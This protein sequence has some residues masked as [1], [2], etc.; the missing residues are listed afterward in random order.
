MS[1]RCAAS[2]CSRWW[3]HLFVVAIVF[4]SPRIISAQEEP[5]EP[6]TLAYALRELPDVLKPPPFLNDDPLRAQEVLLA[7]PFEPRSARLRRVVESIDEFDKYKA[8]GFVKALVKE[9]DD[10]SGLPFLVGKDARL[11]PA[12]AR[13]FARTVAV[14]KGHLKEVDARQGEEIARIFAEQYWRNF[15]KELARLHQAG[16]GADEERA[17]TAALMQILLPDGSRHREFMAKRFAKKDGIETTRAL[18][19]LAL[20]APDDDVRAEAIKGLQGRPVGDYK[21]ILMQGFRYPL[22]AVARRAATALV[23]LECRDVL[24]NLIAVLEQPDPRAPTQQKVDGKQLTVVR[25]LVRFNHLR[26]CLL[27]HAPAA[28]RDKDGLTARMPL[29]DEPLVPGPDGYHGSASADFRVR[30]D[31]T[32]LRQDFSL[33]MRVEKASP[34]PD[35][36]RFDFLVRT[37]VINKQEAADY[38]KQIAKQGVPPSHAAAQYALRELTGREADATPQA[39]RKWL[40]LP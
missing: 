15:T 27:C 18:A 39:W 13:L 17:V 19:R 21:E 28:G 32:Y 38:E 2:F 8:D 33:L 4:A 31:V 36:Q 9:R 20:F 14:V 34:W 3:L 24:A 11:E 1:F 30:F 12:R 7:G 37:R 40:K 23:K 16:A 26:N 35:I 6:P 25:E 29:S 22:P 10:L 5:P